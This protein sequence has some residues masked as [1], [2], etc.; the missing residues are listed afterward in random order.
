[1]KPRPEKALS[2]ASARVTARTPSG[3]VLPSALSVSFLFAIAPAGEP[4]VFESAISSDETHFV[5]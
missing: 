4:Q 5:H 1:M 2:I 3:A